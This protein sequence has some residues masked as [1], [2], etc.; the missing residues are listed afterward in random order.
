VKYA[1]LIETREE[2]KEH[3]QH[4]LNEFNDA[5]DLG[6]ATQKVRSLWRALRRL[7]IAPPTE[8]D[9]I[10]NLVAARNAVQSV[11][12]NLGQVERDSERDRL[13]VDA[14]ANAAVDDID[15]TILR[16]GLAKHEGVLKTLDT[17]QD[18]TRISRKT[19]SK[20]MPALLNAGYAVQPRG[21]KGGT[22]I[23]VAGKA[24]LQQ[25]AGNEITR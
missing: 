7:R 15:I 10:A 14:A 13:P 9:T 18:R 12:V 24:L 17:L 23:G 22:T 3:C 2:L 25:L 11:L 20:R 5:Q 21:P 8:P 6:W 4:L 16:E 1:A 19:I